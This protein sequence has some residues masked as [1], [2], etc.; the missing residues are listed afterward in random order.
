MLT[1][2]MGIKRIE[3]IRNEEITA[4]AGVANTSQKIKRSET[5]LV[6]PCGEKDRGRCSNENMGDRNGW[7]PKDIKTET[8]VERCYKK[9]HEGERNK[10]RRSEYRRKWRLKT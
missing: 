10:D 1:W 3:K 2:V 5:E 6:G 8:E 9:I 4:R 7:T